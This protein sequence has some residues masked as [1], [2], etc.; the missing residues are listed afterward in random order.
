VIERTKLLET[1]EEFEDTKGLIRR[2]SKSKMN[3][4][5]NTIQYNTIQYNTIQYNTIQY[6]GQKKNGKRNHDLQNTITEN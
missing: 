5:Y 6:N 4:Q 3:I 2:R 1:E